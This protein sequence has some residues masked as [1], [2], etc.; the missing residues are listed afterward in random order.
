M[1][2]GL[3]LTEL[4]GYVEGECRKWRDWLAKNPA[5]LAVELDI[6]Q[7]TNATLLIQH[8]VAVYLRYAERL[9]AEPVTPYEK[10]TKDAAALFAVSNIAFAK[11][12]QYLGSATESDWNTVIEFPTRSAGTL[13]ASKRKIF[14]H[15]LVHGIG[16]WAQLATILRRAGYKQDWQHDFLMTDVME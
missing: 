13:S 2:P 3:T 10:L 16:H 8:I 6:A 14:V 5:A 7:A 11:L 1:D 9:L 15:A 4:L 12:R